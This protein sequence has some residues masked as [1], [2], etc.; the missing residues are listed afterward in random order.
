MNFTKP[1][2]VADVIFRMKSADS[3]RSQN[4]ASIDRLFNGFAPY[5]EIERSTLNVNTNFN[6]L[7]APKLAADSRRTYYGAF[8]KTPVF[9]NVTLED[10]DPMKRDNWGR[11]ITREINRKMKASKMYFETLRSQL[12]MTVLHGIAP[13][14]WQDKEKWCPRA[15]GIGDVMIPDD[16]NLAFDNMTHFAIFKQYTAMELSKLTKG[17]KVDPAWNMTQVDAA[18]KWAYEQTQ[19][20]NRDNAYSPE[21]MESEMKENSGYYG[22]DAAPTINVWDFYFWSNEGGIS[23][24]RRRIILD[25]PSATEAGARLP[26]TN[27]IGENHKSWLYCPKDDR[28]YA[29]KI[30]EVIH[31]QFG[32]CSAV[33]PFKYHTVR[34]L[35]WLLYSVCHL[36]NRLKCKGI[37]AIFESL[38]QYFRTNNPDDKERITK[39]DLQ[40]F[41]V[42]PEGVA[43]V[44]QNERWQVNGNLFELGLN[45]NR[46]SMNE[47]ASQF[48]EGR[49]NSQSK[50]AEKTATQVMA[51][52]NAANALVG[53]M[54]LQSYEYAR[55]QDIE[56]CRRFCIPNSSDMDVRDF[57]MRV[58]KAGV[59]EE[60]LNSST[61]NVEPEKAMGSGNKILEVAMA[62]KLMSVR[63]LLDPPGQR[64]VLHRYISANSDQPDYADR[65]VPETPEPSSSVL[66]A[67][68]M[69]GTLMQG[70]PVPPS[71]GLNAVEVIPTLLQGSAMLITRVAKAPTMDGVIGLQTVAQ[72]IG[73]WLQLLSQDKTAQ[74]AVKEF[75]GKLKEFMA[76]VQ[77]LGQMLAQQA[78]G[79]AQ[80]PQGDPESAAKI[81]TIIATS[82]AKIQ[83][84]Q[85]SDAQK[86]HQKDAQFRAN[87]QHQTE[88]HE[89]ELSKKLKEVQLF[90]VAEGIKA[91]SKPKEDLETTE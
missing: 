30:D 40:N 55:S 82:K 13:V 85:E 11:T 49:D 19:A 47:A 74:A 63:P 20:T 90:A 66:S 62:D 58:L 44:T 9:F 50:G 72:T 76:L 18:L 24:W 54:L 16:T 91:G 2:L 38:M 57:R 83:S 48:R 60:M 15:V 6:D 79:Q 65:V 61:W 69:L 12:A 78:Q 17:A 84:R 42:V 22:S 39:I 29:N 8:L 31:F 73:A 51:E 75:G 46:D 71:P 23:G 87:L 14:T 28:I 80:Q 1:E 45:M 32:D 34:S 81:S 5:T 7:S 68:L 36:Q 35:G 41:G 52:V 10:G 21:K 37:D 33:A 4:R 59:P 67:Q 43:F 26:E 27:Q 56:I 25:A 89:A 53:A 70:V 77:Q 88:S 86:L 3:P 64:E